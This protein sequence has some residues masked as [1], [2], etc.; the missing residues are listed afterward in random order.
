MAQRGVVR[1]CHFSGSWDESFEISRGISATFSRDYLH[2]Q[3]LIILSFVIPNY[4]TLSY[5]IKRRQFLNA[6]ENNYEQT[7]KLLNLNGHRMLF[8]KDYFAFN[9]V[10]LTKIQLKE[11]MENLNIFIKDLADTIFGEASLQSLIRNEHPDL[12]YS[13]GK[14][15]YF[16]VSTYVAQCFAHITLRNFL[17]TKNKSGRLCTSMN[18]GEILWNLN[19][20]RNLKNLVYTLNDAF[21]KIKCSQIK[22]YQFATIND[23]DLQP[24]PSQIFAFKIQYRTEAITKAVAILREMTMIESYTNEI[25]KCVFQ[26]IHCPVKFCRRKRKSDMFDTLGDNK[27]NI[28]NLLQHP[29]QPLKY[30]D[31]LRNVLI[32]FNKV[33]D[34]V[35]GYCQSFRVQFKINTLYP[36]YILK[37]HMSAVPDYSVSDQRQIYIEINFFRCRWYFINV[38]LGENVIVSSTLLPVRSQFPLIRGH[39]GSALPER[40]VNAT[41]KSSIIVKEIRERNLSLEYCAANSFNVYLGKL[42]F[43]PNLWDEGTNT[44]KDIIEISDLVC[45]IPQ[46]LIDKHFKS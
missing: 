5:K 1:R 10:I 26:Y 30:G 18:W 14:G 21:M 2:M 16:N 28:S 38:R 3:E 35:Q 4:K 36:V 19:Y 33:K 7:Y 15:E 42:H 40:L 39:L 44:L 17:H 11:I 43:N 25:L 13:M 27:P 37:D 34:L 8:T 31:C 24:P 46:A 29:P 23:Y 9:H 20:D 45:G 41:C 6:C 32:K 12:M 22:Q